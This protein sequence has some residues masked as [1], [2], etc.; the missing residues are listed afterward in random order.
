MCEI[1]VYSNTALK[2][3]S[4]I[5]HD[6]DDKIILYGAIN[7]NS[8]IIFINDLSDNDDISEFTW[9]DI[10]VFNDI[11]VNDSKNI[12][13]K[14]IKD[15]INYHNFSPYQDD[16]RLLASSGISLDTIGINTNFT[17][18]TPLQ[19][20]LHIFLVKQGFFNVEN[21]NNKEVNEEVNEEDVVITDIK[22]VKYVYGKLDLDKLRMDFESNSNDYI[23]YKCGT[24]NNNIIY[25]ND[26]NT[27]EATPND[28][29]Q[30]IV[31]FE[32]YNNEELH[33]D[34]N[35]IFL[36]L[37]HDNTTTLSELSN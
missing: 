11:E 7:N 22:N 36:N 13:V 24:R 35:N 19:K 6:K 21:R 15:V 9:S 31:I 5:L 26:V 33:K 1:G 18:L 17:D 10:K 28:T 32:K 8:N 37:I 4:K 23:L 16:I 14:D 20:E 27:N 25:I 3:T 30:E 12:T 34:Y 2:C 29:Y